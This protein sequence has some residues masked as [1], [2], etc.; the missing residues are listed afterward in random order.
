MEK[1]QKNENIVA[2]S[3]KND[4]PLPLF[5]LQSTLT[6]SEN[7]QQTLGQVKKGKHLS[8]LAANHFQW[9]NYS[10]FSCHVTKNGQKRPENDQIFAYFWKDIFISG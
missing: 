1:W 9:L 3:Q 7:L 2:H 4:T 10:T 8:F 5:S 6:S